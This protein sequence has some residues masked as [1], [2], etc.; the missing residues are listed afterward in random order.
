[1]EFIAGAVVGA[2]LVFGGYMYGKSRA[3]VVEKNE[4][5]DDERGSLE[6]TIYDSR[7]ERKRKL[8]AQYINLMTYNG[9]AQR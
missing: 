7:R 9:E 5:E 2:I 1:M 4:E 6:I 3:P 8:E